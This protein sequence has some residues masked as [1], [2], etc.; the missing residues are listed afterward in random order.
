MQGNDAKQNLKVTLS[1]TG[2]YPQQANCKLKLF[3]ALSTK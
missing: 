1:E 2:N 3:L